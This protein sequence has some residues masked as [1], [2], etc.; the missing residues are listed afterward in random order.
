MHWSIHAYL[1]YGNLIWGNTYKSRI[2]KLVNIQKKIVRLMTFKSYFEHSE[3][4][5]HHLKIL[6]LYKLNYYLTSMFMFRYFHLKNLPELFTNYFLT[7]KEIHNHNIRNSS[8]LHKKSNRTN[9]TKHTLSNKGI[10]VWNNL[11]TQYKE[12]AKSYD[13][14]KTIIN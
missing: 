14:F 12:P 10:E 1:A 11:P 8:W 4:I 6:S 2:Q 5:F 3:P 9:Y 7:N 13:S